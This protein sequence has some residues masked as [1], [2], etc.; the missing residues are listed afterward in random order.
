MPN[1]RTLTTELAVFETTGASKK[2]L[3]SFDVAVQLW[4]ANKQPVVTFYRGVTSNLIGSSVAWGAF[5]GMKQLTQN[6]ITSAEGNDIPALSDAKSQ[7]GYFKLSYFVS[8]VVAGLATQAITNPVFVVKTRMLATDRSSPNAY[9]STAAAFKTIWRQEGWRAF[10]SG[11]G[12]ST[13]SAFQ[14]GIQFAI[15]DPMTKWYKNQPATPGEDGAKERDGRIHPLVTM[16]MSGIGRAVPLAIT[17][18][19]Q[20]I[21]SRLQV[22]DSEVKFGKGIRGVCWQLW[23]EAGFRGFYRGLMPTICRTMPA[24]WATFLAYEQLKPYLTNRWMGDK[25]KE[26]PDP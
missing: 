18:P 4:K 23:K 1:F 19:Y 7:A 15:Y 12:I 10:Y 20:V 6:F 26:H 22:R 24:T 17:Y 16:V 2:P 11:M 21:R 9:P 8:A 5:F 13:V 3:N 25:S 14:G